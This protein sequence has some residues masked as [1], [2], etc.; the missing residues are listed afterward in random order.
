MSDVT[1]KSNHEVI[2]ELKDIR[3]SLSE[4]IQRESMATRREISQEHKE[5]C[6]SFSSMERKLEGFDKRIRKNETE[7]IEINVFRRWVRWALG[8]VGT[9]TGGIGLAEVLKMMDK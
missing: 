3:K 1:D 8:I 7:L 6:E 4:K 5:I 2:S 9:G